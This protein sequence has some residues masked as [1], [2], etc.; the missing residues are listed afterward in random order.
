MKKIIIISLIVV[1]IVL[2]VIIRIVAINHKISNKIIYYYYDAGSGITGRPYKIEIYNNRKIKK[3]YNTKE[4]CKK[5]STNELKSLQN[6]IKEIESD[7]LNK[8]NPR[9]GVIFLSSGEEYINLNRKITINKWGTKENYIKY[10]NQNIEKLN[11][12]IYE[13]KQKYLKE[14]K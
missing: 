9:E 8:E 2:M 10:S 1:C 13:I 14:D 5:I 11:D 3:V 4:T 12:F 7:N 6:L